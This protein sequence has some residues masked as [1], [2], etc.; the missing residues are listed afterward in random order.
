[1]FAAAFM[2]YAVVQ[3]MLCTVC[4]SAD[5]AVCCMLKMYAVLRMHV[6]TRVLSS[7]DHLFFLS[8]E[9]QFKGSREHDP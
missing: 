7:K 4:C 6:Y 8:V 2:L 3:T 1:M 5:Y 9:A